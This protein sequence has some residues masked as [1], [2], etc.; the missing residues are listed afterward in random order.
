MSLPL[1]NVAGSENWYLSVIAGLVFLIIASPN[2]YK[3]VTGPIFEDMFG[4]KIH[5]DGKPTQL[6]LFIHTILFIIIIRLMM[7]IKM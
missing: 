1:V 7:E 4:I 3:T 2:I 5:H 6:G